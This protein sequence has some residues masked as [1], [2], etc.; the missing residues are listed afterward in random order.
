[1]FRKGV[2]VF[3]IKVA[4]LL[5]SLGVNA[6]IAHL[7]SPTDFGVYVLVFSIVNFAILVSQLGL[8]QM[9]VKELPAVEAK[10]EQNSQRAIAWKIIIVVFCSSLV[11]AG[12]F[13]S[14]SGVINQYVFNNMLSGVDFNWVALWIILGALVSIFAEVMRGYRSVVTATLL[15][16]PLQFFILLIFLLFINTASVNDIVIVT[17]LSF[18]VAFALGVLLSKKTLGFPNS[19]YLNCSSDLIK[20]GVPFLLVAVLLM[21]FDQ[22]DLWVLGMIS[23]AE[24]A[25]LY[26]AAQRLVRLVMFSLVIINALI[27]PFVSLY[28]HGNQQEKLESLVRVS[29]TFAV[30]PTLIICS[31]YVFFG[32]QLLAIVFGEG[33]VQAWLVLVVLSFGQMVNV[34]TGAGAVLLLMTGHQK[35]FLYITAGALAVKVLLLMV[36]MEGGFSLINLA[37]LSA[38]V[39]AGYNIFVALVCK[40]RVGVFPIFTWKL[41]DFRE[42]MNALSQGRLKV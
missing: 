9:I 36:L 35:V 13:A 4:M 16:G 20:K 18:V 39:L 26:G 38:I 32:Q 2:G 42:M 21:A 15:A 25:A 17:T 37:L 23:D 3:S 27:P 10:G 22:L 34:L 29:V 33:Y 11:V 6:A 19:L 7:V 41:K 31:V 24:D 5:I 30:L 8:N 12:F 14:G 28:Y 40:Y 1:M